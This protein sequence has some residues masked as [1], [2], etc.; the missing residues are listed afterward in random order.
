MAKVEE[1]RTVSI[2]KGISLTTE[3]IIRDYRI[4]HQSRLAS[5]TG[6][7]EVMTGK[8]KFGI[9][10]DGKEVAQLAMARAFKPGDTRSGYYR[11]QT[12]MMAA[13]ILTIRQ[14]FAQ[15]YASPE[16]DK[17]PSSA[18]RQ[19][20]AHFA[21]RL[22]EEDGRFKN[23]TE[24][25]ATSADI[26]PTGAQMARLAGLAYASKLYRDEPGLKDVAPGFSVDGDEVAFGTIGN[27]STSEGIFFEAINAA[28]VLQ[29]PMAVS[30]WDDDYGISVPNE[31]QTA[32][33]SI[34][35]ALEGFRYDEDTKTGLDIYVVKGWDYPGL[36]ET[37]LTAIEKVRSKHIP[38]LI[39]VI[40]MTQPQGHSTSGSHE[41]Y[42]SKE[43]LSWEEDVDCLPR[44]RAW[45]VD[46]D[47]SEPDEL[48]ALEEEDRRLVSEERQAAW[49][50]YIEPIEAEQSRA[51][52]VLEAAIEEAGSTEELDDILK[53][54]AEPL[55]LNRKAVQ[56][57]LVRVQALLRGKD[58]EAKQE[59][60]DFLEEYRAANEERFNSHLLS[61]SPESPLKV[62][63]KKPTYSDSSEE[64]HGRLVINR[65]FEHNF[66][67]DPRIFAIGED[68]GVLGGVNLAFEG[69]QKKY[70]E[71]RCTDTGIREATILGQGIGAAMR[72]L[73][74]IVD[75]QYLDYFLFCL[76]VAS[77]DLA[78]LRYRTSGGQKAP[79][80]I[81][82]K[83]HRLEGIWH[84][85]SPI[86]MVLHSLRGL[87][88]CVPRNM[89]QAAGMY[90]TLFRG[91]DPALV[92]EVLSGYRTPERIPD[93]IGTF[94]VPLGV[95]EVLR[96][97]RDVTVVTYGFCCRVAVEAAEFLSTMGIEVEVIDVQTLDPFDTRESI[98]ESLAKTNALICLDEDVPGGASAYLLQQVLDGQDGWE[99]LDAPPRAISAKPNRS[100]YGT[101]GGYFSKPSAEDVIEVVYGVMQE[102]DPSSYPG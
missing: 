45:M 12:F 69:L 33:S 77:D 17:D 101:D 5:L 40:E 98:A 81:R 34:S 58:G 82:T 38:A 28:A 35:R 92:I 60:T 84:T 74:P 1:A 44:M 22:L 55:T 24:I 32:H 43:R 95:P 31:Y 8:A 71:L 47:I 49:T 70:G 7:R 78:T 97:G 21:T 15:L 96:K 52:E 73:R 90:N 72:G 57:A 9:F 10:G 16:V 65:C 25:K 80:I 89:T 93:N 13:G 39:H 62:E 29:I 75:I 50:A 99:H 14:F 36:V 48:D 51:V 20:N 66:K 53:G 68:I 26:S 86:G 4:A 19:M 23:L 91:D 30:V 6:H 67:R 54:L 100:P 61:D 56:S 46:E 102:R 41:R 94:T 11:D 37:Y 27:A 85:G 18:G 87:H 2:A 3:E 76:E 64:V 83:G 88:I 42:K 79:V 63:E 59:L